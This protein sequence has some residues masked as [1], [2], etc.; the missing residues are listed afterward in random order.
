[1]YAPKF[2]THYSIWPFAWFQIFSYKW[3]NDYYIKHINEAG[4]VIMKI[5]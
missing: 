5:L 3:S 4:N 1:M 2:V